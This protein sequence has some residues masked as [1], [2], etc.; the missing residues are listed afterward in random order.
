MDIH[1]RLV[2]LR[3]DLAV[4]LEQLED[5]IRMIDRVLRVRNLHARTLGNVVDA[6]THRLRRVRR[7][8]R[9]RRQF[10]ARCR[11]RLG[12]AV[13]LADNLAQAV[14]HTPERA[15][16][17]TDLIGTLQIDHGML[18]LLAIQIEIGKTCQNIRHIPNGN[19]QTPLDEHCE[20]NDE[21]YGTD[22]CQ[23][24][25]EDDH[26][27]RSTGE[28]I[29]VRDGEDR[30]RRIHTCKVDGAENVDRVL[31]RRRRNLRL[32]VRSLREGFLLFLL[33]R[34]HDREGVLHDR[35]RARPMRDEIAL[36]VHQQIDVVR[37]TDLGKILLKLRDIEVE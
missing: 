8:L 25:G 9:R 22:H 32:A 29:L 31:A 33:R 1:R 4:V 35:L 37:R 15:N 30:P 17:R 10:L 14:R 12:R 20:C 2:H 26:I 13:D 19:D 11:N 27:T 7:V 24:N 34:L 36:V 6:L 3:H 21:R 16:H 23:H 5:F 28:L 18:A